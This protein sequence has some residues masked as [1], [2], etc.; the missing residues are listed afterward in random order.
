MS[1]GRLRGFFGHPRIVFLAL[2]ELRSLFL[3]ELLLV[4]V[5]S[6]SPL[7][8]ALSVWQSAAFTYG[9][10]FFGFRNSFFFSGDLRFFGTSPRLVADS[11]S[12]LFPVT[13][14]GAVL[15]SRDS[16]LFQERFIPGGWRFFFGAIS[17]ICLLASILVGDFLPGQ[18]IPFNRTSP[19]LHDPRA[20]YLR[21]P[22]LFF[23]F[24]FGQRCWTPY[25]RGIFP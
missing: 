4:I 16:R 2:R 13:I 3:V 7:L 11:G 23:F 24:L 8:A 12:P 17:A 22:P 15:G 9:A 18:R 6:R 21:R 25:P 14:I 5:P 19:P 10:F 20:P 1:A